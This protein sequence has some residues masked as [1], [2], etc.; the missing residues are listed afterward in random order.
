MSRREDEPMNTPDD[1]MFRAEWDAGGHVS[2][3]TVHAWLDRQ[4]TES[5]AS[6]VQL[7]ASSCAEC[8][9]LVAEARGLKAATTRIVGSLDVVAGG[10]VP[11]E[12]VARTASHIV[13]LA[14]AAEK[15]EHA[16]IVVAKKFWRNPVV[17]RAAAAIVVMVGGTTLVMRNYAPTP[18]ATAAI[19]DSVVAPA[20]AKANAEAA[21]P[22]AGSTGASQPAPVA[23]TEM[24][25]PRA[26]VADARARE[27]A[28]PVDSIDGPQRVNARR[29]LAEAEQKLLKADALPRSTSAEERVR[30]TAKAE[31]SVARKMADAVARGAV[32]NAGS[33]AGLAT[34]P[35]INGLTVAANSPP[36]VAMPPVAGPPVA[37]S[38]PV[39]AATAA[40]VAPPATAKVVADA[41]TAA[42]KSRADSAGI[43][44][45]RAFAGA[46]RGGG[47]AANDQATRRVMR[48]T[49][50]APITVV[51]SIVDAETNRPLAGVSVMI[52]HTTIGTMTSTSG[53]FVLNDVPRNAD[54]LV[55]RRLGYQS[56]ISTIALSVRDTARSAFKL[57]A[58]MQS[59]EGITTAVF[60]GAQVAVANCELRVV[61][62]SPNQQPIFRSLTSQIGGNG[63]RPLMVVGWPAQND[64]V[65]TTMN[66]TPER[67][68]FRA[69]KD[70]AQLDVQLVSNGSGWVGTAEERRVSPTRT[71]NVALTTNG[72]ASCAK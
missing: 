15:S 34:R 32:S 42:D 44:A 39:A 6:A 54:S 1:E 50:T 29:Q 46:G 62:A 51:G 52:P 4:L 61:P 5:D 8:A 31:S 22:A 36:P 27:R 12:D 55:A 2:E 26:V 40:P 68:R 63:S 16:K 41:T 24:A 38:P 10:I 53:T 71:E 37:A 28:E 57:K 9:D 33:A 48:D 25:K 21:A 65:L 67:M 47:R 19:S 58:S 64:T 70:G 43:G 56:V 17:L 11:R 14:N 45:A 72:A 49:S 3:D 20:K 30:T 23:A 13:A 18:L 35:G 60:A 7:H 66:R 69:L 59:L